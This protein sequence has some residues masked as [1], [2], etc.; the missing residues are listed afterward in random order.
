M[1]LC[2]AASGAQR[3]G[4]SVCVESSLPLRVSSALGLQEKL[5]LFG[6]ACA[7]VAEPHGS[8]A[9]SVV[10]VAATAEVF[11]KVFLLRVPTRLFCLSSFACSC[12]VAMLRQKQSGLNSI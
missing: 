1:S 8:A 3:R 11:A 4:M 10:A 5:Q 12:S 6:F 7:M 9:S 2:A